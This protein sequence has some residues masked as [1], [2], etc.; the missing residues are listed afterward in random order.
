ML[1]F[2]IKPFLIC[3]SIDKLIFFG[4]ENLF[5]IYIFIEKEMR[6]K[7]DSRLLLN[8]KYYKLAK[9]EKLNMESLYKLID[10]SNRINDDNEIVS[11]LKKNKKFTELS[12][13]YLKFGGSVKH[14]MVVSLFMLN[15]K[16]YIDLG[17]LLYPFLK[18]LNIAA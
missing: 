2:E 7:H 17:R 15:S 18:R 1:F 8:D 10:N 12:K 16:F 14:K 4:L 11:F 13:F 6:K 5:N 3:T 9:F